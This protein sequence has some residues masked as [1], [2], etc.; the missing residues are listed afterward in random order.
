V[1]HF[2]PVGVRVRLVRGL[3]LHFTALPPCL[4]SRRLTLSLCSDELRYFDAFSIVP[5]DVAPKRRDEHQA[6][7]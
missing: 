3:E 2:V 5:T 7:S 1:A 4:L 6:L